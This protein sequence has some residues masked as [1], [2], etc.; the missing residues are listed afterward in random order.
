MQHTLITVT[1]PPEVEELVLF[2]VR[3]SAA[4]RALYVIRNNLQVRLHVDGR[5]RREQQIP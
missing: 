2:K 3:Y 5:P 1:F 4:V